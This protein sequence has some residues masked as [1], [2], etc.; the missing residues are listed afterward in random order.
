MS[1]QIIILKGTTFAQI[2]ISPSHHKAWVVRDLIWQN[3]TISQWNPRFHR[4]EILAKFCYWDN[5]DCSLHVPIEYLDLFSEAFESAGLT[6]SIRDK[7][8]YTVRPIDIHMNPKFT[9]RPH[10]VDAIQYL[11]NPGI[12]RKGLS[13][14]PGA[15]KTYSST[16][17]LVNYGSCG[18]IIVAGLIEQW[19]KSI[20]EQTDIGEELYV[21][22]GIESIDKLTQSDWKP[23]I[24]IGSLATMRQYMQGKEYYKCLKYNFVQFFEH[25]GIG[26]K[27]IDE[28]HRDFY[29]TTMMDLHLNVP[30]NIYLTATF[31]QSDYKAK[32]IFDKIYPS[33][34]RFGEDRYKK[35]VTSYLYGYYGEIQER[36]VMRQK[37]YNHARYETELLRVVRRFEEWSTTIVKRIVDMHYINV[38]KPGQKMLIFVMTRLMVTKLREKLQFL[39]PN[40]V[41]TEY[42][43]GSPESN[44]GDGVD[45]IITVPKKGGTGLDIKNLK[46][47]Y[48]TISTRAPTAIEQWLG[49]LRELKDGETL[50]YVDQYDV[51]IP[52]HLRHVEE[53]RII[54]KTK[55]KNFHENMLNT[56]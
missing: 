41:I 49:R 23:K 26:T 12:A 7:A 35:Y 11:S 56:I 13:L 38:R 30:N 10:Q 28:V 33:S 37:G 50:V 5:T 53:R 31:T 55:S 34:L 9:D 54:L 40:L 48:N 1:E 51:N 47:A 4:K 42:V 22:Q 14:Q 45:I 2:F 25:Y 21:L 24:F 6:V 15:G 17:A 36:K 29:A 27:I 39:Y 32:L 20:R 18:I 44:I 43:Q 8:I 19:V 3:L 52:A 46:T 16:K